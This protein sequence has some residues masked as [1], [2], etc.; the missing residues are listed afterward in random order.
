MLPP[1]FRTVSLILLLFTVFGLVF[2]GC[3][4]AGGGGMGSVMVDDRA[5]REMSVK[6]FEQIKSS[7]R[8]LRDPKAKQRVDRIIQNLSGYVDWWLI[9]DDWEVVIIDNKNNI[10]A[11]AMAGGKIGVYTGLLNLVENDDQLAFVLAHEISHVTEKH[12]HD[13]LAEQMMLEA[14]GTVLGVGT[15]VGGGGLLYGVY[16]LYDMSSGVASLSFDREKEREA[17]HEGLILMAKAGYDPRE[18]VRIVYRVNEEALSAGKTVPPAWLSTH[19]SSGERMEKLNGLMPRAL[20]Y[21]NG[22][23]TQAE[24]NVIGF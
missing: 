22:G 6:Q 18:A 23:T 12:V 13:R 20:E 8:L 9:M 17:D 5:V 15:A 2:S 3:G 7:S 11:F 10:N 14:G 4:T 19:P 1:Y 16:T 24:E 21:Y